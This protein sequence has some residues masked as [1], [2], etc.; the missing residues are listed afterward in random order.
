M[1]GRWFLA[2]LGLAATSCPA[3]SPSSR[4]KPDPPAPPALP[5]P[6]PPPRDD[7]RLSSDVH[8]LRYDLDLSIDPEATSLSGRVRIGVTL[9]H[10]TRAIV[11]HARGPKVLTA[12]I[13]SKEGKQW[14]QAKSRRA[15]HSK[16]DPEELVLVVDKEVSAGAAEIDLQY[17]A[18]YA[19]NLQGAYRV[20]QGGKHFVFTQ[21]EPNDARRAFPCFD[22]PGFK[23]PVHVTLTVPEGNLAVSNMP[24]LR[25]R[26]NRRSG[27]VSYEFRVSPPLPTYLVAFAVGAFEVRQGARDPVPIRLISLPGKAKL[28]TLALDAARDEL[29]LLTDYFG[30]PY[31]YPKLDLVAV[32]EFAAGAM[33]NAGLITFREE[34]LLLDEAHTSIDSRRALG[35]ILAHELAH[36]WFG[37]LVTMKWWNNVWLNEGFA[38]WMGT[39]ISD[40]WHPAYGALSEGAQRK[41][42]VM[43]VDSLPS[44]RKVRQPVHSSSE[45]LEAFDGITYVK[46][47]SVLGMAERWVGESVMRRGVQ[48]YLAQHRFGKCH[49]ERPVFGSGRRERQRRNRHDGLVPRS[50][51]RAPRR[52]RTELSPSPGR[53]GAVAEGQPVDVSAPGRRASRCLQGALDGARLRSVAGPERTIGRSVRSFHPSVERAD[54]EGEGMPERVSAQRAREWVLPLAPVRG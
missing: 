1:S 26:E 11:L 6:T 33:E 52:G 9:D 21:F 42:W 13:S 40:R 36:Q 28:G 35:G 3:P 22:E 53:S 44:A 14:A 23:V 24:E 10:P 46:G 5:D 32:P 20:E 43:G 12:A 41:H 45:A 51:G 48:N 54:P 15:S 37:N 25:K 49:G 30:T 38:T 18:P 47:A 29:A 27:L 31:P 4:W 8:P 34:R 7:G 39:K 2:L 19:P 17:E 16:D 50:H